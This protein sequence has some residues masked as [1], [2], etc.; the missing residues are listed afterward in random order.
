[1]F[2]GNFCQK[3]FLQVGFRDLQKYSIGCYILQVSP[4]I[5]FKCMETSVFLKPV[6]FLTGELKQRTP[7]HTTK[8]FHESA[9]LSSNSY[10]HH[11]SQR[12]NFSRF[13]FRIDTRQPGIPWYS[14]V[15]FY[16]KFKNRKTPTRDLVL[17]VSM[18]Q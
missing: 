13:V 18:L 1:M 16:A 2:T 11:T 8:M 15:N 7:S 3:V 12:S 6:K 14:V 9:N 4:I 10:S 17:F 5:C